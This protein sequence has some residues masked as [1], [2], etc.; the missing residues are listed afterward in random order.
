MRG[1]IRRDRCEGLQRRRAGSRP[2]PRDLNWSGLKRKWVGEGGAAAHTIRIAEIESY[3][4]H[5]CP[6]AT[7]TLALLWG[8]ARG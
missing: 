4:L 7:G 6:D 5:P 1:V 3:S 2:T 8:D